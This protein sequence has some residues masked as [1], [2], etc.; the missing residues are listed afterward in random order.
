MA[1]R[2]LDKSL[3]GRIRARR[4]NLGLTQESLAATARMDRTAIGKIERGERSV[5]IG[6]LAK[7]AKA[8]HTNM[9]TILEG[10]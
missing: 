10:L 7:I 9:A 3:G 1:D 6:T 4:V 5:T 8:L 2:K